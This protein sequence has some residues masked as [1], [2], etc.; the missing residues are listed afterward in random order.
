MGGPGL[1][2]GCGGASDRVPATGGQRQR[3][4]PRVIPGIRSGRRHDRNRHSDSNTTVGS[5]LRLHAKQPTRGML[6]S[7]LINKRDDNQDD[8]FRDRP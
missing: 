6:G 1:V 5:A 3:R 7:A 2:T 4:Y 8:D